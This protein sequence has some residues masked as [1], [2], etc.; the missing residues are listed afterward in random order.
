MD[1]QIRDLFPSP[2]A[3]MRGLLLA[4]FWLG[5]LLGRWVRCEPIRTKPK[6]KAK[7]EDKEPAGTGKKRKG[8][9]KPPAK[10]AAADQGSTGARLAALGFGLVAFLLATGRAPVL[11]WLLLLVYLVAGFAAAP[12]EEPAIAEH[13]EDADDEEDDEDQGEEGEEGEEQDAEQPAPG[14][15]VETVEQRVARTKKVILDAIETEVAAGEAGH[16]PVRGRG[17][18]VVDILAA[19]RLTKGLS[20]PGDWTK[21]R[22]A[23]VITGELGITVRKQMSFYTDDKDG[24]QKKLNEWGVHFDDLTKSIGHTPQLPARLVPDLTRTTPEPAPTHHLLS[25]VT[26]PETGEE[27]VA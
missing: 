9:K 27:E 4:P 3:Y 20:I 13:D 5:H 23:T 26:T 14:Q 17:A 10:P 11:W 19:L 1:V 2:R 12:H 7:T 16:G 15:P 8:R 18:R 22:L 24:Q 6:T 21:E 25:L